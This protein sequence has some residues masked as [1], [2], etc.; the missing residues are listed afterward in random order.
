MNH[1]VLLHGGIGGS[2]VALLKGYSFVNGTPNNFM[3]LTMALK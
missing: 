1:L 2:N 3:F